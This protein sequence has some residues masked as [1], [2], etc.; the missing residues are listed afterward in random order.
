MRR[1]RTLLPPSSVRTQVD[2]SCVRDTH[3]LA[4]DRFLHVVLVKRRRVTFGNPHQ[5]RLIFW[6]LVT[7]REQLIGISLCEVALKVHEHGLVADV[8]CERTI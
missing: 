3:R 8:I 2:P 6:K 4:L 1:I 5:R 7:R